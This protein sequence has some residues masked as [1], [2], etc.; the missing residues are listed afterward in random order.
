M[1][2]D[3]SFVFSSPFF[4]SNTQISTWFF[5]FKD[6]PLELKRRGFCSFFISVWRSLNSV[7]RTS[8]RCLGSPQAR[9]GFSF[10]SF[11]RA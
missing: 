3:V 7:L 10:L 1:N 2:S 4:E 6:R 5:A 11:G 8:Q 9:F